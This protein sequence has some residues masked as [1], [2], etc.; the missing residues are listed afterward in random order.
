[1][2]SENRIFFTLGLVA[3][4]TLLYL[5]FFTTG[6]AGGG[7]S[8]LHYLFAKYAFTHPE[9]YFNHWAKPF[10]TALSSPFTLLGFSGIKLFN[11]LCSCGAV[12]F[13]Y[14][15]LEVWQVK[16]RW[17][18]VPIVFS[19]ALFVTV[20][21]SGLTEPLS[22]LILT[23]AIYLVVKNKVVAGLSII[24]FMPFVRSEG[25]IILG[26]F[27][28]YL[29]VKNRIKYLPFLLLGHVVYALVGYPF[30]HDILWIFTKIPYANQT[31]NYGNGNW[32]HFLIQLNFQTNPVIYSLFWLGTIGFAFKVIK[33]LKNA[34]QENGFTEKLWLV[35]GCFF[36]FF[37]AHSCFWALGIFNSLGLSRVFVSVLPL[38]GMIAIDGLNL[39]DVLQ[40]NKKYQTAS[41]I[42]T[43]IIV[44]V[45]MVIPFTKGKY[46][47]N[48][49]GEFS[50]TPQQHSLKEVLLPYINQHYP[51][52]KLIITDP[53]IP[54]MLN[55][56]P[57]NREVCD[58][59]YGIKSPSD[60]DSTSLLVVDK[61]FAQIEWGHPVEELLANPHLKLQICFPKQDT[62]YYVFSKNNREIK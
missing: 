33:A 54:Y 24:S 22:A 2:L 20:T 47:Y 6:T 15:T 11:T 7:D 25:L 1:M 60:L 16:N 41:S 39:I 36:A 49:P 23:S 48:L 8:V 26:V 51:K 19:S 40:L 3:F 17:A 50:L 32:N 45:V 28:I 52:A 14:K 46:G 31:S 27:A 34:N 44:A 21:Q 58:W 18:I 37:V 29:I 13:S 53:N 55:I 10:F 43:Y 30:Y 35:Y 56:D 62:T 12:W 4:L 57:F 38:L 61:W 9:N 5:T 42:L 59:Y